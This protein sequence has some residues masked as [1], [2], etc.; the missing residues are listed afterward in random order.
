MPL[1]QCR[2]D[3]GKVVPCLCVRND[4]HDESQ[5]DVPEESREAPPVQTQDEERPAEDEG[6]TTT[7]S[8]KKK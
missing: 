2:C 8:N 6:I 3:D 7:K 1:H 5:F 4:D